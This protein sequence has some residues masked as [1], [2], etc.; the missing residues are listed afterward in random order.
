MGV[1]LSPVGPLPAAVYWRRRA[2]V[3]LGVFLLL[4]VLRACTGGEDAEPAA[5]RLTPV[6]ATPAA[7]PLAPVPPLT[8][9][10]PPSTTPTTTPT[11]SPTPSRTPSPAR[12]AACADGVLAVRVGAD[13]T[14]YALGERP[15]LS[16]RVVNDGDEPC[17]RGVGPGS[18][19][20]RVVSGP[21]R[22][23][24]SDD[25]GGEGQAGVVT[26]RP[27]EPETTTVAWEARRSRPGCSGGE[28]RIRPGTYRVVGRVGDL[29]VPGSAFTVVAPG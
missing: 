21:D 20:L 16:L 5:E 9:A 19:E 18:V 4:F 29:V 7:A 27:G 2:G 3:L 28:E 10:A 26:L 13:D 23:W 12:P 24:S 1:H 22:I 17:P 8:A 15:R 25:C 6:G 11:S 14:R